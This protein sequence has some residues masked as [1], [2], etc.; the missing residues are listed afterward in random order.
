[1]PARDSWTQDALFLTVDPQTYELA[2]S[3]HFD[4]S[5]GAGP[6]FA[7]DTET[8]TWTLDGGPETFTITFTP[9]G[10]SFHHLTTGDDQHRDG[11]HATRCAASGCRQSELRGFHRVG[12]DSN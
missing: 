8:G 10:T 4:C 6:R 12:G 9:N 5:N 3:T 7:N 2:T 11:D 1:M